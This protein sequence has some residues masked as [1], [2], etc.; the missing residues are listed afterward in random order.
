MRSGRTALYRFLH[1]TGEPGYRF[2][3]W[4]E[5]VDALPRRQTRVLTWPMVTVWG[6][7]AQPHVHIFFKPV[8][9]RRAAED[10]GRPLTYVSRPNWST[11]SELLQLAAIVRRDLLDMRPGDMI[12]IPIISVGARLRRVR[13]RRWRVGG[14]TK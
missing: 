9:T 5:D 1:G 2:A 7:L 14:G 11:Y 4:V 13:V 10:Y 8:V 12:D 3:R 6:F